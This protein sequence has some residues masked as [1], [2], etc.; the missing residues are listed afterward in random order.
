MSGD[1]LRAG[2]TVTKPAAGS[3]EPSRDQ[4][5]VSRAQN[6]YRRWV[7]R[8]ADRLVA[9]TALFVAAY[10][11][12]D[13]ARARARYP[14]ARMPWEA[15]ETVAESFGDLDPETDARE[16]DLSQGQKW[17]GWH[18][19]EKDL[20]PP[21]G[22]R[23]L[24]TAQRAAVADR[25]L[26]DTHDLDRRVQKLTYTVD[27]I[28]NGAKSLLDEVATRKVTGEEEAFSH[29]DLYD[30]QANVDGAKQ[31][32]EGLVPLLEVKDPALVKALD[33]RFDALQALLDEHRAGTDGF[34]SYTSLTAPQ[35][36]ALSDAVNALSEPLSKL[37]A[38]VTL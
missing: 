38:A 30:F 37:T 5:L 36:K 13:D 35:V 2:F 9:R 8:Q 22:Y 31:A 27:Q 3:P 32:F 7:Q 4:V 17:T 19:I 14:V 28:G 24:G 15:I 10:E 1:G 20:W 12:G 21:S 29:T 18:R 34:A 33:T 6:D 25:L 26:A 23:P 11:Q 16:A